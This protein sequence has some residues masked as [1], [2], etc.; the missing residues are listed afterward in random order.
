MGNYIQKHRK[1]A[2]KTS[3][4]GIGGSPGKGDR[5]RNCFSEAFRTNYDR[6]FR[7]AKRILK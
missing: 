6:I 2:P 5:P 7:Q 1:A 3:D 4:L